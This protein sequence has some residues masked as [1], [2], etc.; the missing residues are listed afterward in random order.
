MTLPHIYYK[1]D[2]KPDK[3][4]LHVFGC[5]CFICMKKKSQWIFSL[6]TLNLKNV[7]PLKR[8]RICVVSL[9][10]L[11]SQKKLW[12]CSTQTKSSTAPAAVG[13][14]AP[15][16]PGRWRS[17]WP[18]PTDTYGWFFKKETCHTGSHTFVAWNVS[19]SCSGY[20]F[21]CFFFG[22]DSESKT[23]RSFIKLTVAE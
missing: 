21:F 12:I 13:D 9:L 2:S 8:K 6:K 4:M 23:M 11:V 15:M 17:W 3:K 20:S 10:P 5:F 19:K 1:R 18:Q 22:I 14:D 7:F 16:E